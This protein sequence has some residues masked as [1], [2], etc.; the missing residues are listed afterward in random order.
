MPGGKA[1]NAPS[2]NV[3]EEG[4]DRDRLYR[5]AEQK[6]RSGR[7]ELAETIADLFYAGPGGLSDRERALIFDILRRV[8]HD[9]EVA[10]R[11]KLSANLA[12]LPDAPNDLVLALAN[13]EIEVAYPIL[14]RSRVIEDEQL[15][16]IVQ[17]RANE[18]RLAVALRDRLP[19]PVCDALVQT[20]SE[21]VIVAMLRNSTAEI[22]RATMEY[23]VDQSRRVNA[24][25]EPLLRRED[26]PTDLAKRMYRWVSDA[27]RVHI[28]DNF[29]LSEADVRE[30]VDAA[31]EAEIAQLDARRKDSA[32]ALAETLDGSGAITPALLT[33]T[34]R[35]GEV[36][37]FIAMLKQRTGLR[38][39]M[40]MRMLMEPDG[41]GLAIACKAAELDWAT[42]ETVFHIMSGGA[43]LIRRSP[44]DIEN[45]LNLF[46]RVPKDAA[47]EV[48]EHWRR[49][50]DYRSALRMLGL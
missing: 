12:E 50:S 40:L 16:E 29:E 27:L 42:V 41:E 33:E 10:V 38:E 46:S 26:L 37:L 35:E 21:S 19:S 20:G 13:D 48:V 47:D 14:T 31:T 32:T 3:P 4:F 1:E 11:R 15:I 34:L 45:A 43:G 23:L 24:F 25:Q 49:S 5:L 22:S 6:T 28:L 9:A 17:S 7:R 39:V 8:I 2:L 44:S 36:R 30:L 18:H